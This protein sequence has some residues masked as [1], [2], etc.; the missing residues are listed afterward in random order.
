MSIEL[1]L[2][3]TGVDITKP[4]TVHRA[5]SK[6]PSYLPQSN[7]IIVAPSFTGKS[8]LINNLILKKKFRYLEEYDYIYL[9]SPTI[10]MDDSY[11]VMR[12]YIKMIKEQ[13]QKKLDI[14]IKKGLIDKE[15]PKEVDVNDD[16]IIFH[17]SYDEAFIENILDTKDPKHK[18]LFILDDVAD[19]LKSASQKS[20]LDRLFFRGR[21][22]NCFCWISSQRYCKI[23]PNIRTNANSVILFKT[24]NKDSKKIAEELAE[25]SIEDFLTLYNR[26]TRDKYNFMY[27]D[28]KAKTS[29][30]NFS[31]TIKIK[32]I[33][34]Q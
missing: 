7:A 13:K 1:F 17:P 32:N 28:V 22:E 8:V 26:C 3:A 12:D 29:Y 25:D 34:K 33:K 14:M 21:H 30:C 20:I 15:I 4:P 5:E 9:L 31:H 23:V 10:F 19:S 27:I 24:N 11:Q 2:N 16:Q 6:I 18:I